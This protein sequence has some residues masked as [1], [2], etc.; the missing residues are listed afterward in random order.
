MSD[1]S[2]YEDLVI[3]T[4]ISTQDT[5]TPSEL[6]ELAARIADSGQITSAERSL[7]G[8][9]FLEKSLTEEE[10]RLVNRLYRAFLRGRFQLV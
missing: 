5:F 2:I 4:S 7:L 3:E 10:H 9:A 8:K 6:Y 1:S